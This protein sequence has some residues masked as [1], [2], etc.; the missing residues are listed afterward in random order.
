MAPFHTK[1]NFGCA[2][3]RWHSWSGVLV[4]NNGFSEVAE[5]Y[6]ADRLSKVSACIN[7]PISGVLAR[8]EGTRKLILQH[9]HEQL[10]VLDAL[11]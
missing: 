3:L 9:F 1:N 7:N 11:E 10:L 2:V 6:V 5:V 4:A 8:A